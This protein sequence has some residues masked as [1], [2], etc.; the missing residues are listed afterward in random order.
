MLD[1][2]GGGYD[3]GFG[4]LDSEKFN[5]IGITGCTSGGAMLVRKDVFCKLGGFDPDYFAYFEDVDFCFESVGV[6]L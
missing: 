6:W 5:N 3:R 4:E 1:Y 2:S